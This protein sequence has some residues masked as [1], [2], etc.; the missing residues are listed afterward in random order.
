MIAFAVPVRENFHVFGKHREIAERYAALTVD[1]AAHVPADVVADLDLVSV[2]KPATFRRD[3]SF[4]ALFEKIFR[5][6]LP[7]RNRKRAVYAKRHFVDKLP[8]NMQIPFGFRVRMLV[9]KRHVVA[10]QTITFD[11][12]R[13][14]FDAD[15]FQYLKHFFRAYVFCDK[16]LRSFEFFF[17][18][19]HKN[20]HKN[21]VDK[22]ISPARRKS[23]SNAA[24]L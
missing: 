10:P 8:Q 24:F 17:N 13:R 14:H 7:E 23:Q 19:V 6:R 4:A 20:S 5:N 9:S 22:T 2:I 11:F 1:I 12:V 3:K 15:D 21:I 16:F 18:R